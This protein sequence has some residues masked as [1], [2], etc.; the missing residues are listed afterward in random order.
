MKVDI[1]KFIH[2]Y[3]TIQF[4]LVKY[5]LIHLLSQCSAVILINNLCMNQKIY[6]FKKKVKKNY[7][8]KLKKKLKNDWNF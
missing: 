1:W 7:L 5:I 4:N 3:Q 2:L 6:K 8:N